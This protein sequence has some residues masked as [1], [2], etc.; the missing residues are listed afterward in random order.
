M[1]GLNVISRLYRVS[2][3]NGVLFH[4]RML[5]LHVKGAKSFE[6][7]KTVEGKICSS[8]KE[9]CV[10]LH[11]LSD[12]AELEKSLKEAV[13]YQMP[14]ALRQLFVTLCVFCSPQ[15]EIDLWEKFKLDLCEDYL[16]KTKNNIELS[17]NLALNDINELLKN[18]DKSCNDEHLPMPNLEM[19]KTYINSNI[20]HLQNTKYTQKEHTAIAKELISNLNSEQKSIYE[21]VINKVYNPN[22]KN[23]NVFFIDGP[24][25]S[26]KTYLFKSLIHQ[27]RSVEDVVVPVAWTGIA[28]SLVDGG[29]TV[30]STFSLTIPL[31]S[32][33]SPKISA[34]SDKGKMLKAA[35][36]IIW[37]EATMASSYAYNSVDLLLRDL[38]KINL[39]FG[40]KVLVM[41]GDFRQ[42]L[43]ILKHGTHVYVF[44]ITVKKSNIW[45]YV[46]KFALTRN[47]RANNSEI[48]FKKWLLDLGDGLLSSN[49]SNNSEEINNFTTKRMYI[50]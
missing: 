10:K 12:D 19:I 43:P 46:Q 24:G 37:D 31:V 41:G 11:L 28:S 7:L 9:A 42:T 33:M 45:G 18:N 23:S 1:Q 38:M 39:P 16:F 8:F 6:E 30:H 32:D 26:G 25:G 29:K 13:E 20:N 48:E 50:K 4:I 44:G 49:Y 27:L 47:M 14:H 40:G 22:A 21:K 35:K 5:L 3:K 17:L 34:A 2:P 15:S 36:L